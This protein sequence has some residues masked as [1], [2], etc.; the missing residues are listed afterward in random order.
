MKTARAWADCF[1]GVPVVARSRDS[2]WAFAPPAFASDAL[3]VLP[4]RHGDALP[5]VDAWCATARPRR[6][7]ARIRF[8]GRAPE[9]KAAR[10]VAA[11]CREAG[12]RYNDVLASHLLCD[13]A[14]F[15]RV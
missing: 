12:A 3:V 10:A 8:G 7:L 14:S 9:R 5:L 6:I 1:G 13:Q 15:M 4:S 11:L 2:I